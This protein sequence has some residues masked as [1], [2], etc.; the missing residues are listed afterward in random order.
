MSPSG[1]SY[2]NARAMNTTCNARMQGNMNSPTKES[3]HNK[4]YYVP[5]N[6]ET[7][8][9]NTLMENHLNYEKS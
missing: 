5:R 1:R 2:A 3:M 4:I 9:E 8:Y 6:E 7:H